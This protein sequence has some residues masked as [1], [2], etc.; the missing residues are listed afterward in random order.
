M[1]NKSLKIRKLSLQE[2]KDI[3]NTKEVD[4]ALQLIKGG[5]SFMCC[6]VHCYTTTGIWI[7]ELVPVFKKLDAM[8]VTAPLPHELGV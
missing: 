1:E 2:F 4:N 6:H 8:L 3:K 7:P 5:G